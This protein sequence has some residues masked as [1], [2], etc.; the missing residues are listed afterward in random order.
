MER[1]NFTFGDIDYADGGYY[2]MEK[3]IG[4]GNCMVGC[5]NGAF[6]MR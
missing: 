5:P 6:I 1:E 2:L 3:C 4:C